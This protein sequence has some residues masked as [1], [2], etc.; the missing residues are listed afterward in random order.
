MN[1]H[2]PPNKK[3]TELQEFFKNKNY[4]DAENLAI[5]LTKAYPS[6]SL[7]WK[8]LGVILWLKNKKIEALEINKV[9]IKL[10]PDDFEAHMHLGATLFDLGRYVEAEESFKESL[11]LK[12]NNLNSLYNL[13]LS[14]LKQNKSEDSENI[15]KKVMEIKNDFPNLNNS[16]G[17]SQR[18]LGKLIDAE[19]SFRRAVQLKINDYVALNNLGSL[20]KELGNLEESKFYLEKSISYNS[21]YAE[22]Y[23]NLGVTFY[24]LD[25][26][27]KSEFNL[28]KAIELDPNYTEAIYNL[29]LTLKELNNFEEAIFY[30]KK[31]IEIN[32]NFADAYY[33]LAMIYAKQNNFMEAKEFLNKNLKLEPLNQTSKHLF[34]AYCGLTTKTAP[35]IYV[36]ELFDGYAK[37]FEDSL[38]NKL[39]YKVPQL[40]TELLIKENNYKSLGSVIDLGCGTGL[41]GEVIKK[42]CKNL[43]GLDIS[44]NM[45]AKAK[46]KKIYDK[47]I[48]NEIDNY[49]S[50]EDLSYE[51]FI[52]ADVFIYI[53]DL[54][55]VFKL[56]KKRNKI[57]AKLAFSTEDYCGEGF[58]LE[59]S[60][61]YSHSKKYILDL[62]K[63]FEYDLLLFEKCKLRKEKKTI[64][65]GG[66]YI[67]Q[68]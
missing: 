45:L 48:K 51:Y 30:F 24:A 23:N 59:T 58:K 7:S 11:R 3:I 49:L 15:F 25:Q 35:K 2:I 38:I 47:L 34:N 13:G 55:N 31:A 32:E 19:K 40:L 6:F 36:E 10:S 57:S 29:G 67:L 65:N 9:T 50:T 52:F 16:L 4:N 37:K 18:N 28:K 62:C 12:P 17:M 41:F 22:S 66:L 63:K 27:K 5:K 20:L 44:S 42:Y 53:G 56:I 61:R 1:D 60:G 21:K 68:T 64:I 26:F 33:N 8:I 46:E 14:L 43:E 54:E 39:D